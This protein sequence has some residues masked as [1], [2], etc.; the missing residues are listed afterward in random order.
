[1][2]KETL[3][4]FFAAVVGITVAVVLSGIF[5]IT[6]AKGSGMEPDIAD[7]TYVIIDKVAYEK[8]SQ[9]P[10]TGDIVAFRSSIYGEE[11]EGSILIRRIAGA[12]GD[13]VGIKDDVF[14]LNGRPYTKYMNEAVHMDDMKETL[15]GNDEIF[16]LSDNRRSSMDS[17][18]EAIG[19]LK[20]E[21]CI[22]K[23]CFK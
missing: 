12:P 4:Y 21:D 9:E 3:S 14:Y 20:A 22:G 5:T 17:R 2:L 23:V 19:I 8:K 18:N 16:V 15:L 6:E 10:A 7:G 1:M 13:K 11:G